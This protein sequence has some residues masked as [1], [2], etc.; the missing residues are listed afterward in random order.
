MN[1]NESVQKEKSVNINRALSLLI[2]TRGS[3]LVL[4]V[5]LLLAYSKVQLDNAHVML[6]CLQ[7]MPDSNLVLR[8]VS[9]SASTI[10][11]STATTSCVSVCTKSVADKVNA[12]SA[13]S[14]ALSAQGVFVSNEH[15]ACVTGPRITASSAWAPTVSLGWKSCLPDGWR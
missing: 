13:T 3:V 14:A 11:Y 12:E 7:S 9:R 15:C 6:F 4:T 8:G 10:T 5:A 1:T 2:V